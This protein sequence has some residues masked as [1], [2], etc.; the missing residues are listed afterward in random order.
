[1]SLL[2]SNDDGMHAP[3]LQAL[4]EALEDAGLGFTVVAP[5]RDRSGVSNCLTLDRP[6]QAVRLDDR[7]IAVDGTPTDCIHLGT[8][9]LFLPQPERVVSGINF[10]ANLGDDVLYSGTVAAAMEGRFLA[11]PALAVSLAIDSA[12]M[13]SCC[14]VC[15]AWSRALSEAM[16]AS[17]RLEMPVVS[18]VCRLETNF[19]WLARALEP[20]PSLVRRCSRWSGRC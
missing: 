2:V 15:R 11:R 18:E 10:G 19:R 16:S 7:R 5:D 6:L 13:P 17:T 4:V 9:G 12:W 1:M 3:G 14:F 20:V 8:A